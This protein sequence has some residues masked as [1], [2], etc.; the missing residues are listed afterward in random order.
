M[1]EARERGKGRETGVEER[2]R[3]EMNEMKKKGKLNEG[4][5]KEGK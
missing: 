5:G 3:R 2:E 1:N 4:K